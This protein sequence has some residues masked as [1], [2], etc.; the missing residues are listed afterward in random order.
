MSLSVHPDPRTE[1][2]G[3][4]YLKMP[5]GSWPDQVKVAVQDAYS[6]RWLAP[7]ADGASDWRP[8]HHAFGPY[9]VHRHRDSDWVR[10]GPE[11][12]DSI[13]EYTPL[14]IQVEDVAHVM[15]WPDTVPPRLRS[16]RS[17]GLQ[18]IVKPRRDATEDTVVAPP[19]PPVAGT[20]DTA[21]PDPVPDPTPARKARIWPI[22]V[23]LLIGAGAAAWYLAV[24]PHVRTAP[25]APAVEPV[26]SSGECA[27]DGLRGRGGFAEQMAAV[28]ACGSAVSPDTALRLVEDAAATENPQA[29]LLFGTLYDGD[30]L[31]AA[32]ETG[33]GLSFADDP[34]RAV[35]YYA[36]AVE[37]GSA[38]AAEQVG[39][40]CARL[41]D[42]G[43]T[44]EKGAY[45]D[46]CR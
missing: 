12:I 7:T 26:A 24:E 23:L 13:E 4:G 11:I 29:L 35:E 2:G 36:R 30:R 20:E 21:Q 44:L 17:G 41:Q 18:T 6:G 14:S 34:A 8:E 1:G 25:N 32:I 40:I 19:P 43:L 38:E 9:N 28:R 5:G 16:A 3:Y 33:V 27:L 46:Y 42:S 39:R 22:L 37:A 45:D 15:T 31:D 10:I